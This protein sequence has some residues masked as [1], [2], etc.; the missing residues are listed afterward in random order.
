M[1]T[2]RDNDDDNDRYVDPGEDI[3]NAA[4]REVFEETGVR[5]KFR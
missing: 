3:H 5:T 4:I 1:M 2:I